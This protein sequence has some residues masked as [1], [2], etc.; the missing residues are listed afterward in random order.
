ML[1]FSLPVFDV[2]SVKPNLEIRQRFE[3]RIDRDFNSGNRDNRSE[4]LSRLRLG[5]DFTLNQDW[6]AT[7]QYQ[8]AHTEAWAPPRNYS[9]WTSD[10]YQAFAETKSNGAVLTLGRQRLLLGSQRL[11]G[12]L[13]WANTGRTFDAVRIR[14]GPWDAWAGKIGVANPKPRDARVAGL[15]NTNRMGLSSIIFK[16]DKSA[17]GNLD[18]TTLNHIWSA[19]RGND[20]F[21]VEGALQT[22]RNGSRD[23]QAWA[24]HAR[25]TRRFASATSGFAE[26]N[27]ASGGSDASK[28]KTFDNLYPT[29]H[30]KYG[31]M[32]LQAWKNMS[33]FALGFE[34]SPGMGVLLRGSWHAFTLQDAKDAWYG[35]G[36][37]PNKGSFGAFVD[38]TGTSGKEV[39]QELDLET[40]WSPR[41]DTTFQ[42]GLGLF[43]PGKFVK[44]LSGTDDQQ[45]WGFVSFQRKF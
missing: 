16:H 27:A 26:F 34:H 30:D 31:I 11:I 37:N 21:D 23:Q 45:F 7:L 12:S 9:A 6:K 3:R 43:I 44:N 20:G 24:F 15:T 35:A 32:D 17:A 33:E 40:I 29:N 13:E 5:A 2:Q 14:K 22:G 25:A 42:A 39:G 41:K 1:L 10:A 8:Y 18:I 38:P 36:G 28:V 4:L 19:V